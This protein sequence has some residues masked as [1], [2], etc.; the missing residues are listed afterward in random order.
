MGIPHDRHTQRPGNFYKCQFAPR[1]ADACQG[2][3]KKIK[4]IIF[5]E[6]LAYVAFYPGGQCTRSNGV[7]R[8]S[9]DQNGRDF[10]PR[11]HQPAIEFKPRH[12]RHINIRDQAG[13]N[14]RIS[15][16][17]EVLA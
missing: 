8:I 1:L 17:Q 11:P 5:A 3:A 13:G 9:R 12:S 6:R 2:S 10:F 14:A 15:R 4:R 7:I 16:N